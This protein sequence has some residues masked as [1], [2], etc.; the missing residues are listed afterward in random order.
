MS[1]YKASLIGGQ[2]I[3]FTPFIDISNDSVRFRVP[4]F[5][6]G[7]EQTLSIE[8]ITEISISGSIISKT[9]SIY[10]TGM[11][12]IHAEGFSPSDAKA[13][14]REIESNK[15]ELQRKKQ[16][17]NNRYRQE[18]SYQSDEQSEAKQ[19]KKEFTNI[20]HI[21]LISFSSYPPQLFADM[22]ALLQYAN[23]ELKEKDFESYKRKKVEAYISKLEEGERMADGLDLGASSYEAKERDKI[24]EKLEILKL[25]LESKLKRK[26]NWR[27]VKWA[28]WIAV[29][30]YVWRHFR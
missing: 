13:V 9:I 7:E 25:G 2:N 21:P 5:L 15:R 11:G 14:Q 8:S 16:E 26:R 1:R 29:I 18:H 6:S 28:I 4:G 12:A 30:L 24:G 17:E 19:K 20:D 22:N 23:A 27:L 3:V 10:T